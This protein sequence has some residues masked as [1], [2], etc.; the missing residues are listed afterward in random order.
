M[1][2]NQKTFGPIPKWENLEK[3]IG[4]KNVINV[5]VPY[6]AA[7]IQV[8]EISED[9]SCIKVKLDINFFNENYVGVHFGGSL[10]A[11]C[12]PFYMF[13][14]MR[15]LGKDYM[16][17]DKAAK[18]DFVKPGTGT[19]R[20]VFTISQ[21]ELEEIKQTVASK[22]KMNCLF[23]TTVTNEKNEI[24]AKVEKTLYVRKLK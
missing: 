2:E 21:E 15:K 16:V 11:M 1:R 5:Y 18:I 4:F 13:I 12:D 7:G 6:L 3:I 10:Y 22:K 9:F 20:A 8:E 19:V 23:T 17:W 24:V 14:L